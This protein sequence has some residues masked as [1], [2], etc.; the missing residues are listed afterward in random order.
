VVP[1]GCYPGLAPSPPGASIVDLSDDLPDS[2]GFHLVAAINF[3]PSP[4]ATGSGVLARLTLSAVGAGAGPLTLDMV[5]LVNSASESIDVGTVTNGFVAVG[6][7]C[8]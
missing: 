8:P 3:G 5:T 4:G 2:D 6:Q 7:P 1:F